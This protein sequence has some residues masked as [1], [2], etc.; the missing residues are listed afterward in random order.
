MDAVNSKAD[1]TALTAALGNWT[2]TAGKSTSSTAMSFQDN[3]TPE[4]TLA[5]LAT[6]S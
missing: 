5:Q 4:V 2:I 6:G 3:T 1:T